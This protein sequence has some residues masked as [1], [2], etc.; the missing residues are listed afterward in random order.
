MSKDIKEISV[1]EL[2]KVLKTDQL[3]NY[4]LV[5]VRTK[6][7]H[8]ATRIKGA[9]NIPLDELE[10]NKAK[11]ENYETIFLHCRSGGRSGKACQ[12]LAGIDAHV[13]NVSGG[14]LEWQAEGFAVDKTKGF[15]LPLIQQVHVTAGSM[16][17]IGSILAL[18]LN[19]KWAL[20]SAFVGA[21]LTFAGATGWC[22]MAKL[23][24]KMPWNK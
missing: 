7:E 23:L 15:Y 17:L 22:G 14:I 19:V 24:A 8:K 20:L 12:L 13:I 5:D 3:Q 11:L 6:P 9:V 16:V 4:I 2:N 10:K 21:G 1:H 18:T